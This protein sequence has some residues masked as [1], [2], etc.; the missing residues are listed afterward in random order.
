MQEGRQT[1]FLWLEITGKC[2][3]ECVHCYAG[4]SPRGTHGEMVF[5]DWKRV[6]SE[7]ADAGVQHVQFI[8]GEP[9]LHPHLDELVDHALGA[10]LRVE[11][12]YS[13][14]GSQG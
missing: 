5:D 14:W 8:G 2:Q 9:T 13:N 6:I 7:A 1:S 10:R 12:G 4:S 11:V 3:L